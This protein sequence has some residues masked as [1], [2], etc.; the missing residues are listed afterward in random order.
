[1][2][3]LSLI[4]E[5]IIHNGTP[6]VAPSTNADGIENVVTIE[7]KPPSDDDARKIFPVKIQ[8]TLNDGRYVVKGNLGSGRYA[9]VWLA[10]D[11]Q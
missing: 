8:D 11:V 1:M 6:P 7:E 2:G 5:R 3:R 10:E 9:S 4:K